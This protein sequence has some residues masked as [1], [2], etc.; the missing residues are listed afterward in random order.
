MKCKSFAVLLSIA[1]V[2]AI[3]PHEVLVEVDGEAEIDASSLLQTPA[4]AAITHEEAL[5]QTPPKASITH[6][7]V[8]RHI[9]PEATL[10]EAD[11]PVAAMIDTTLKD[12]MEATGLDKS[13]FFAE[14]F[15]MTLFV[16]IGCG[17]A[18]AVAK[19]PGWVLQVSLS[20]G[21]GISTLAYAIGH[22]SG[23]HIN[24]AVTFALVITGKC[25]IMQGVFNVVAQLMGAVVGA[26]ILT[27]MFPEDEDKTG[28][29]GANCAKDTKAAFVAELFGT[30]LLV[31]VVFETAVNGA[32]AQNREMACLAI[33]LAVFLAH[34]VMI[35]IDGCS[36][37]PARSFGPALVR[38]LCYT[39]DAGSFSD[40][41]IF[42]TGP[43]L[44]AAAAAFVATKV[45][46]FA[47]TPVLATLQ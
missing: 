7:D 14:F 35:P 21:F 13:A 18:C 43:L 17:S 40:M 8:L 16:I 11:S 46:P 44:G 20:F 30:F 12:A 23:G 41:W 32:S 29:L 6:E 36:I 26:G 15:A 22:I 24:P 4:K 47:A 25:S 9:T 5:L 38:K 37:N 42:W 1:A 45:L 28:G 31:F 27:A 39:K 2:A 3:K 33:G 34:S 10:H 19:E